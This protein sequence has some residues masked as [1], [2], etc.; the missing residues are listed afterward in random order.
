MISEV[1]PIKVSPVGIER[2][3]LASGSPPM[4]VSEG[5]EFPCV[6]DL[7]LVGEEVTGT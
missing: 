3:P 7:L 6:S 5:V 4:V 1:W 2:V